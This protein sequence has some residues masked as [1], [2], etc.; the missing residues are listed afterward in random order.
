MRNIALF[1]LFLCIAGSAAFADDVKLDPKFAETFGYGVVMASNNVI[2]RDRY[3]PA[4]FDYRDG[5]FFVKSGKKPSLGIR[6]ILP[7]GKTFLSYKNALN[8]TGSILSLVTPLN[9]TMSSM[10]W[11]YNFYLSNDPETGAVIAKDIPDASTDMASIWKTGPNEFVRSV[12]GM[13]QDMSQTSMR[14]E[15]TD[16]KRNGALKKFLVSA[17][18]GWW[19]YVTVNF[20]M[21]TYNTDGLVVKSSGLKVPSATGVIFIK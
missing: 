4:A 10:Y 6:F 18:P 17:K 3:D 20:G 21:N 9:V 11:N 15:L 14:I 13:N 7:K 19:I 1:C 12:A 16:A 8:P 5:K 2:E